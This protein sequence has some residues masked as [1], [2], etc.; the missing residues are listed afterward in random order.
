MSTFCRVGGVVVVLLLAGC[1]PAKQ[2]TKP[3]ASILAATSSDVITG[4]T[5]TSTTSSAPAA[6]CALARDAADGRVALTVAEQAARLTEFP[7]LS[8]RQR[9]LIRAAVTDGVPQITRGAG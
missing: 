6:F 5:T 9:A 2:T 7:G 4:V 1:T 8:D 3:P